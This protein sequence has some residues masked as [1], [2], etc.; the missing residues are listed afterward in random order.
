MN[1]KKILKFYINKEF[2]LFLVVGGINTLSGVGFSFIY[3]KY[4]GANMA[5][6]LGY[7]TSLLISYTLNTIITFRDKFGLNRFCKFVFSYIPN[8]VIQ[9][10]VV[11]IVYNKMGCAEIVAYFLAAILGIPITFFFMKV[12]AFKKKEGK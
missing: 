5:F 6:V 7:I 10:I 4:L 2:I 1:L 12:F 9:N 8:F 3:S 11:F